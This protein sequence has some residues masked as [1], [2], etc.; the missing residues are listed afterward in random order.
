[1]KTWLIHAWAY[2]VEMALV[3]VWLLGLGIMTGLLVWM[4]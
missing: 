1:M 3:L 2:G 4:H